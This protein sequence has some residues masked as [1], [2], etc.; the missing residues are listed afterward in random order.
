MI[1]FMIKFIWNSTHWL[2][3]NLNN[4]AAATIE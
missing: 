2:P 3:L 4:I 1:I